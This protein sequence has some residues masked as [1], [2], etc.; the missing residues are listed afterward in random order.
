MITRIYISVSGTHGPITKDPSTIK[1]KQ[2]YPLLGLTYL[3]V[4]ASIYETDQNADKE[5]TLATEILQYLTSPSLI[6]NDICIFGDALI[7]IESQEKI[8]VED[9]Y[10]LIRNVIIAKQQGNIPLLL[11]KFMEKVLRVKK[12]KR[13][14][15]QELEHIQFCIDNYGKRVKYQDRT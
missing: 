6:Y 5:N 9:A 1:F 13:A 3:D 12:E 8:T 10:K 14:P 4:R 15:S 11:Q 2:A 7:Q